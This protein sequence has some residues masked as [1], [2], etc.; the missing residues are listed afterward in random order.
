MKLLFCAYS[1]L[2]LVL[3]SCNGG[4]KKNET[5]KSDTVTVA[6]SSLS[7]A[8]QNE[9]STYLIAPPDTNYTGEH[10][11][12]YPN[13]N[14]KF[15]GFFRFG[16]RHGQWMAFYANGVLWSECF[17]D[18]GDRHGLNKVYYESGKIRYSG[19]FQKDQ[20]DSLWVFYDE[21]GSVLKQIRFKNDQEISSN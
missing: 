9:L 8:V 14:T 21:Y 6:T 1:L 2:V 11:D 17:Y 16:K 13:G 20:R 18:N 3:S 7:S 19:F 15:R 12:K 4:D 5:A 10:L